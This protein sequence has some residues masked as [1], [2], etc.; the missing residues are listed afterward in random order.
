MKQKPT[1]IAERKVAHLDIVMSGRVEVG[2]NGLE[3]YDFT[4]NAL[5]EIDFDRID[6]STTFLGKKLKAPLLISCMTG[7]VQHGLTIN[8]NLAKTASEMGI[9][10]GVGSQRIG[11]VKPELANLFLARSV[12]PD[13]LLFGNIGAVQL[14]YGFGLKEAKEAVKMIEADALVLHLNPIQEIVQPEGDHNFENLLPK[15]EKLRKGLS[16]P[17]I[18]KEVGNGISEDVARR[19]Y[20]VGVK[21]VDTAG[22]GGTSWP[23]VEGI[24]GNQEWL[25]DLFAGWGIK[26]ADSI[27]QCKKVKGLKV[28]GSGGIRNGLDVAKAIAL[29]ANLVGIAYPYAQAATKSTEAAVEYTEKVVKQLKLAMFG[30]GAADVAKLHKIKLEPVN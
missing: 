14:N 27:I 30:V 22:L 6:T 13:I 11:I 21:I 15:I 1:S 7:G 5:P 2:T 16:V 20:S 25:G 8:R 28:I 19:L 4:H 17:I 24:R 26:T 23:K 3:K 12:A 10:M 18:V 9:A 29:G